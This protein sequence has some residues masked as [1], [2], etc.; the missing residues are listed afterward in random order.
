MLIYDGLQPL[1]ATSQI[2]RLKIAE[3]HSHEHDELC[4]ISAGMPIVRHAGSEIR[5]DAGTLFLFTQGEAHGVW[6]V[7]ATVARIWSL[8]F[9]HQLSG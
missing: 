7:G 9:S 3:G 8:E 2:P 1:R 4:L 6:D 5:G